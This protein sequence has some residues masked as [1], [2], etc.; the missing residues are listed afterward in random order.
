MLIFVK[1]KALKI[2]NSDVRKVNMKL[3][4]FFIGQ[5]HEKWRPLISA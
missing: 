1:R 2:C 4:D 5:V 3:Y